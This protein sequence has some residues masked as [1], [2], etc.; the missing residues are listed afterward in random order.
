MDNFAHAGRRH[1]GG[2]LRGDESIGRIWRDREEK[3]AGGLG[4]AAQ[5]ETL[6]ADPGFNLQPVVMAL[7]RPASTWEVLDGEF[8]R[9][10]KNRQ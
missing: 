4:I 3:A 5:Q 8:K 10:W 7:I 9:P 6:V 1:T 2:S